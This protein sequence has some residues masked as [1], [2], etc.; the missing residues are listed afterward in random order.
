MRLTLCQSQPPSE[1]V[2][3]NSRRWDCSLMGWP[4]SLRF[5]FLQTHQVGFRGTIL[6][7]FLTS[8]SQDTWHKDQQAFNEDQL[9]CLSTMLVGTS[10]C[11]YFK[12]ILKPG[13]AIYLYFRRMKSFVN[14]LTYN[15]LLWT[16][17][18]DLAGSKNNW[19]SLAFEI[20]KRLLWHVCR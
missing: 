12:T 6:L 9:Q 4:I 13:S 15:C 1:S 14:C 8:S 7:P 18:Y 20:V 19:A 17:S 11:K 5:T 3:P 16:S 2:L 10:Y